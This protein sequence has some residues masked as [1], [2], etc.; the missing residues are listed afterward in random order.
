MQHSSLAVFRARARRAIRQFTWGG[1]WAI[2]LP[3]QI[4]HNLSWFFFDGLFASAS[5]NIIITYLVLYILALGATRAQVGLMSSFSSL[6]AALFLLMG[7][8]LVERYGHRK[9]I[10]MLF[11][12]GVARLAILVLA[13]LPIFI[14][15]PILVWVAI[16][17]SVTRDAFGNLA[18]PAW[19]SITG[20]V[21]PMEGR[22]RFFGSRNF[23]MGI[24][25]MLVI[26]LVGELITQT[27]KPLGFQIA[28]GLAFVFGAFST[29]SFGHLRVP[30]GRVAP[31]QNSGSFSLRIM[32]RDIKTHP[33]F[34][35][36]SLVM[37]LWNFS[38]NIAGPFFNVYMVENLKFTATMIGVTSIIT[39]VA[40][41]LVQRRV[42]RLSDR[43]GSRTVMLVSM[44]LIPILPAAWIFVT[45]FWHVIL[46]NS[47]GG[48]IWGA[49][50]LVSFN[51]LLSLMPDEQ[52]ARYSAFYQ[53]LVTLAL[54]G[55]AALG[56]WVVTQWGYQTIFICSAVGRIV[57]AILFIRFVP[58]LTE[59]RSLLA[60]A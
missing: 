57:A 48:V 19:M 38:L 41:L 13:L 44:I 24:A 39:T 8:L 20:E 17:L 32:L 59:S 7:A 27:A 15:G 12:G 58:A 55:G 36:L 42:G 4:K 26:L 34:L 10:T 43:W 47:F 18:F 46:L 53:I 1:E 45:K 22:G 33:V 23:I 35:A 30:K 5:D 40:S 29:F 51:F 28:I 50:G 31:L 52:R 60:K 2:P 11:G 16:A 9:E 14:G 21:V 54:A 25:G 56:S 37:A 49:F 3:A 6:S